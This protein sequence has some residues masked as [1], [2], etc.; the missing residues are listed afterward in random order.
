MDIQGHFDPFAPYWVTF[1]PTEWHKVSQM[2]YWLVKK[3][4]TTATENV[5]YHRIHNNKSKGKHAL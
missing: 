2:D 5:D 3:Y 4:R 1:Y